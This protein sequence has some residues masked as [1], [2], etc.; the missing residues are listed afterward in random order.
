[1]TFSP[2]LIFLGLVLGAQAPA[3]DPAPLGPGWQAVSL[4]DGA[5]LR[6]L[7]PPVSEADYPARARRIDAQGTSLLRLQVDPSGKIRDCAIARSSGF[8]VLDEHA[9]LLYRSRARF[10]PRGMTQTITLHAPLTWRLEDPPPPPPATPPG[11]Q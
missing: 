7:P 2:A 8:P 3:P 11:G 1:M 9:C 5:E 10:E 6:Y 4:P